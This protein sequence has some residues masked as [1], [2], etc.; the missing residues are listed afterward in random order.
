MVRF[1]R[2]AAVETRPHI[3]MEDKENAQKSG[4]AFARSCGLGFGRAVRNHFCYGLVCLQRLRSEF[5]A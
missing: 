5:D 2:F 1:R 3:E 4:S